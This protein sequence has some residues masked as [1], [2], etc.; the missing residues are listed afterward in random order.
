MRVQ[1]KG[2][3]KM[4]SVKFLMTAV[5]LAGSLGMGAVTPRAET[6]IS[7]DVFADGSYCHMKF[8]SIR[9]DTLAS[10]QPILKDVDDIIDFYGPCNHDPLGKEEIRSQKIEVQ[11]RFEKEYND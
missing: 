2:V 3:M 10:G 6:V 11:H 7:K 9:E 1:P 5:S 4:K 8:E